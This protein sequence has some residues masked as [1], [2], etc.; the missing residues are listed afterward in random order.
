MTMTKNMQ[1]TKTKKILIDTENTLF[2]VFLVLFIC[3]VVVQ[4]IRVTPLYTRLNPD[5]TIQEGILLES[6]EYYLYKTGSISLKLIDKYKCSDV[7]IYLNGDVVSKLNTSCD[8][9]SLLVKDGDVIE[10]KGNLI[11]GLPTVNVVDISTNIE[12]ENIQTQYIVKPFLNKITT[13]RLMHV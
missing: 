10:F 1:N 13:I 3:L 11:V 4:M 9:A 2:I 12:K 5:S 6:Q 7:F 8:L